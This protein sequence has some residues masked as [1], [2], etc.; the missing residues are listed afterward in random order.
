MPKECTMEWECTYIKNGERGFPLFF[1]IHG[2]RSVI[3]CPSISA[4]RELIS[5]VIPF[6]R[7]RKKEA[8]MQK[9]NVSHGKPRMDKALRRKA[10]P[11]I[12]RV[13]S[14]HSRQVVR[15]AMLLSMER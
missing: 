8:M 15:G 10:L 5:V 12:R 6:D 1:V 9:V 13:R 3:I 14:L 4:T 11:S 7:L 2:V